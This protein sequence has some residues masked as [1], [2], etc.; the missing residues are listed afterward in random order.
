MLWRNQMS[1]VPFEGI[2]RRQIDL[3]APDAQT[4]VG[5]L[6]DESHHFGLT[7]V[8][9]GTHIRELRMEAARYPWSTCAEAGRPLQA[10]IG[11]PLLPRASQLGTLAD[12]RLQCT[13]LFDLASLMVAHAHAGRSHRRYHGTVEPLA[14][15]RPDAPAGWLRA[16]LCRDG[17][18]VLQWD[19][20]EDRIMAPARHAGR[21]IY[22]GFR[23]WTE[24]L[25]AEEAEQALVLRRVAFVSNGRRIKI[26]HLGSAAELG[27]A[28]VCYSFQPAQREHAIPIPNSR[29]RYDTKPD[30]MLA[31]RRFP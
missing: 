15:L 28:P 8:H 17:A 16:T 20:H 6:E 3:D 31:E 21:T 4:V 7:L 5:W 18:V 24:T 2:Y 25:D 19:L 26:E 12:V 22:H 23:D 30:E 10:L 29:R 11:K 27:Q 13:H 1:D 14:T 9:D